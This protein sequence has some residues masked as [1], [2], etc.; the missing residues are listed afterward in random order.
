MAPYSMDL[1][2]VEQVLVPTLR[3]GDV[4]VLDNLAMHKQP[5]LI[6]GE[7]ETHPPE[8]VSATSQAVRVQPAA[9]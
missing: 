9:S 6:V 8:S 1:A 5:A 3:P 2:Y 4:V 7:T